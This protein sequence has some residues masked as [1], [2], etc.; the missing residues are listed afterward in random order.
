MGGHFGLKHSAIKT[1]FS[2][3]YQ[4]VHSNPDPK[5]ID[6][7]LKCMTGAY[8]TIFFPYRLY[9]LFGLES[10]LVEL[11]SPRWRSSTNIVEHSRAGCYCFVNN[12]SIL[13][14]RCVV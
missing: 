10:L 12:F 8:L 4:R 9:I 14:P 2:Q 3:K 1:L 5:C 11:E 7:T 6:G 13:P